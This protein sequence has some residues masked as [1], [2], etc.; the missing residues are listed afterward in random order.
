[1]ARRATRRVEL[2]A[3]G[4]A[5][6]LGSI[7]PGTAR[8]LGSIAPGT[9]RRLG[10]I[11]RTALLGLAVCALLA[12]AAAAARAP[13]QRASMADIESQVMCVTCGI[14]LELAVSPQADRERAGIQVMID[15]GMTAAQIKQALVVQ[16]GPGVLAL[17]PR[18]GFDLVVYVVPVLVILG[19][20]VALVVG[21]RRWRRRE[22]SDQDPEP[23]ALVAE[24]GLLDSTRL[25]QDLAR[26]DA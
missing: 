16:L 17:P 6:R 4:T 23:A 13:I 18:K 26:F 24:L 1:M 19:L 22:H 25:E 15:E 9:A 20:L 12:S 7:A 3:P 2:M 5:C 8:R 11:A 14:P 10:L 21:L